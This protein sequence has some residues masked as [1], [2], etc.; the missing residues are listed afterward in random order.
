MLIRYNYV[1]INDNTAYT[2]TLFLSMGG[3]GGGG[4]AMSLLF[5]CLC[6]PL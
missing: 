2:F 6:I 4:G 5:S 1:C 3:S